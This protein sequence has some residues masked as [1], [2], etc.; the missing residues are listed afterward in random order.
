MGKGGTHAADGGRDLGGRRDLVLAV[1]LRD[2]L[3]VCPLVRFV[4]AAGDLLLGADDLA[5]AACSCGHNPRGQRGNGDVARRRGVP[6]RSEVLRA[7]L[8][9]RAL[10]PM[11]VLESHSTSAMVGCGWVVRVR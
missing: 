3:V 2:E 7:T 4:P 9:A 11:T 8:G 6:F 10:E 1:E 5:R